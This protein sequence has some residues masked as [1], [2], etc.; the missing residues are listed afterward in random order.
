MEKDE[1]RAESA[2]PED[3]QSENVNEASVPPLPGYGLGDADEDAIADDDA[4]DETVEVQRS[5]TFERTMRRKSVGSLLQKVIPSHW[6]PMLTPLT[7]SDIEA[8]E[9]LEQLAFPGDER[10]ST[11]ELGQIEYRIRK[12]GNICFGLFNTY[13]PSDD[14]D[15]SI[16]TMRHS[17]PVETGR[18]DNAK[19]VMFA[20]IIAT[21]GKDSVVIDDNMR[22]PEDWRSS[23]QSDCSPLGHRY[24]GRT[25]CLHS[26]AVCPEVQGIG[27]GK[28]AMKSYLQLMNESGVADR[29]ALVCRPSL[30]DFF[31][32]CGF[33]DI[34]K[35]ESTLLEGE[36]HNMI[37]ELPGPTMPAK[38]STQSELSTMD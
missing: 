25:I 32:R 12:C 3:K 38:D 10:R 17:R 4:D 2:L 18:E 20:H 37:C 28:T 11:K 36:W 1:K 29:V 7:E 19:H 21:L 6:A 16:G 35:S 27:I 31:K 26:F 5:I 24:C 14:E 9:T 23:T 33:K 15:W 30:V 13:R 34:G 22:C 8:C